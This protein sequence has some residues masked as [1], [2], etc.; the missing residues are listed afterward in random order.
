MN[1]ALG[2]PLETRLELLG[3][4]V[5]RLAAHV[6]ELRAALDADPVLPV[7]NRARLLEELVAAASQ[8]GALLLLRIAD[9]PELTLRHGHAAADAVVAEV[10]RVAASQLRAEDPFGRLTA[11]EFAA[12]LRAAPLAVAQD[13]ARR[14]VGHFAQVELRHRAAPIGLV[15]RGGAIA[16]GEGGSL[17][18][19]LDAAA[20]ELR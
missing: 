20:Q 1:A 13:K 19:L 14:I 15:V 7:L 10:V 17:G 8:P 18:G 3:R 5:E 9:L 6:T 12:V 2:A 4:E 11:D 16:L